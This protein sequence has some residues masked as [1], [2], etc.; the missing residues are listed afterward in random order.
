MS[1]LIAALAAEVLTQA[2]RKGVMVATAESCTGG[3]IAA[4]LTAIPGASAVFDRGFVTYSNQAKH[5]Q[6]GVPLSLIE[7]F[8]AV[9]SETVQAM[10]EG[11]L[12]Y[13]DAHL[14]IAVTGIAGPQGGSPEKPVGTVWVASAAREGHCIVRKHQF[15]GDRL[16]VRAQAVIASLELL[17]AQLS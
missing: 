11:A 10:A 5:A 9:S 2:A 15:E 7:Q 14:A 13:S 17:L 1:D 3:M 16:K 6:L 4:A 8:G 12:R